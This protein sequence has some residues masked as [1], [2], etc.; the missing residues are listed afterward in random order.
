MPE[1]H[2]CIFVIEDC[3]PYNLPGIKWNVLDD[4]I[5]EQGPL[6]R[7]FTHI[8]CRDETRCDELMPY[9][10]NLGQVFGLEVHDIP[11]TVKFSL[12][13]LVGQHLKDLE[14]VGMLMELI[15]GLTYEN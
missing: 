1:I 2:L 10:R 4:G 9:L 15:I 8:S 7:H 6:G 11:L 3:I 12:T 5:V 13:L 14:I